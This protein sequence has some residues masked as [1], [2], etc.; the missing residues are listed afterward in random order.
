MGW[1]RAEGR[2]VLTGCQQGVALIPKLRRNNGFNWCEHPFGFRLVDEF[3]FGVAVC[4]VCAIEPFG[5]G[6][7]D[8]ADYGRIGETR[9]LSGSISG[10]VQ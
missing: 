7:L 3:A 2:L 5:G 6:I 8:E 10:L 4:V 9:T 1:F